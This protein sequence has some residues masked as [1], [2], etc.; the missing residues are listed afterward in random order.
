M[1]SFSQEK[2]TISGTISD[3]KN[4]EKHN[5]SNIKLNIKYL[6]NKNIIIAKIKKISV[7]KTK[8]E[9]ITL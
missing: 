4:N 3:K 5:N 7:K 9:S 2:F 1:S 8:K 6:L